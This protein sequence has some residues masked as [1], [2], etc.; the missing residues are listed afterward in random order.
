MQF[1]LNLIEIN[2]PSVSYS[3]ALRFAVH[4]L[5]KKKKRRTRFRLNRIVSIRTIVRNYLFLNFNSA[6]KSLHCSR[7]N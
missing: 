6:E 7:N 4:L 1:S 2:L 3:T 5:K